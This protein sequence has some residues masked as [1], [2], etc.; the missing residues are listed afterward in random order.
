MKWSTCRS[1]IVTGVLVLGAL[2]MAC[3]QDLPGIP[4]GP[5][6]EDFSLPTPPGVE[7][8][9]LGGLPAGAFL[10][11]PPANLP[12]YEEFQS[13][14]GVITSV[15]STSE[16]SLQYGQGGRGAPAGPNSSVW[17]ASGFQTS[18]YTLNYGSRFGTARPNSQSDL[19]ARNSQRSGEGLATGGQAAA[20]APM[21]PGSDLSPF[22][23]GDFPTGSG[24]DLPGAG[25]LADPD[26]MKSD[27]P[28]LTAPP[29]SFGAVFPSVSG[30]GGPSM[31]SSVQ[32]LSFDYGRFG[33]GP[34]PASTLASRRRSLN[35]L[36]D[37]LAAHSPG[38]TLRNRN[39]SRLHTR[40]R[41]R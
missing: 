7:T 39:A 3:A 36:H 13:I 28:D 26:S 35:T 25:L 15:D 16:G 2:G 19:F 10:F 1:L 41:D 23:L 17:N 30:G 32:P 20:T 38:S 33:L 37:R 34:R 27:I 11:T 21:A 8:Q 12:S 6:S 24:A 5:T 40:L 31:E 18:V 22:P 4:T 9:R 14:S 29:G